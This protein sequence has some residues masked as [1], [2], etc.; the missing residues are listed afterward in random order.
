MANKADDKVDKCTINRC[1]TIENYN[2]N[3]NNNNK[4][5]CDKMSVLIKHLISRSRPHL[6]S[7]VSWLGT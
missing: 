4:F 6:S 1:S 5:E 2:D 3:N 7:A